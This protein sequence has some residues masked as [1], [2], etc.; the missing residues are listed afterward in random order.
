MQEELYADADGEGPPRQSADGQGLFYL[1]V[2]T[3]PTTGGLRRASECRGTYTGERVRRSDLPGRASWSR[4]R[5]KAAAGFQTAEFMLE[6][7]FIDGDV[8]RAEQKKPYHTCL[9]CTAEAGAISRKAYD[10]VRLAERTA[11]DGQKLYRAYI[12]GFFEL[13]GDR[14][15]SDD[16]QSSG[17]CNS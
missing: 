11:A 15:F 12:F 13:H 10:R 3:D 6:H 16:P 5:E 9:K 4:R 2:L 1:T 7:G 14:R 17:K 8:P